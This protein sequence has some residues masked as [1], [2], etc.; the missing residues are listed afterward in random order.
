MPRDEEARKKILK[1][2]KEAKAEVEK[3]F[4]GHKYLTEICW[5]IN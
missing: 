4:K 3:C 5:D 2:N 1:I